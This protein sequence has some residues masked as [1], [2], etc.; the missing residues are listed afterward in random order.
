MCLIELK[1]Y[2][3]IA[4]ERFV[5]VKISKIV[6]ITKYRVNKVIVFSK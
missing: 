6:N 2:K 5:E 3:F 1:I 4:T